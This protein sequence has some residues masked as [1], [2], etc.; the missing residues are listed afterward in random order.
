LIAAVAIA[1]LVAVILGF[2]LR[3][4]AAPNTHSSWWDIVGGIF[5]MLFIVTVFGIMLNE[6]LYKPYKIRN[7]AIEYV[8]YLARNGIRIGFEFTKLRSS[9]SATNLVT[10]P[11]T[12]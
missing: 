10:Q 7:T 6:V 4:P 11:G 5:V 9:L 1:L 12:D 2:L 3:Q 8:E